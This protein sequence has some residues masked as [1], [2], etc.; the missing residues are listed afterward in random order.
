[1]QIAIFQGIYQYHCDIL[2]SIIGWILLTIRIVS[3]EIFLFTFYAAVLIFAHANILV[4]TLAII[5]LKFLNYKLQEQLHSLSTSSL[6]GQI[7]F[8]LTRLRVKYTMTIIRVQ[9]GNCLF[10]NP[11]LVY[12]L[13][14]C[15]FN[16]LLVCSILLRELPL[17]SLVFTLTV[18]FQQSIG[19]FA[20]HFFGAR[21]TQLILQPVKK[22]IWLNAH[23]RNM[24][25]NQAIRSDC[26]IQ[27]FHTHH[28]YGAA[29]ES[30]AGKAV[31][32]MA[33]VKVGLV[34]QI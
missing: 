30:R 13:V 19:I 14:N 4:A 18:I 28:H 27:A 26:F 15:P 33:F 11:L 32:M 5:A 22:Y 6:S 12:L 29:Y 24:K 23:C 31:S 9:I 8:K 2:T 20:I 16:C 10:A 25:R 3:A 17:I 1:M 21:L 7:Y 34:T